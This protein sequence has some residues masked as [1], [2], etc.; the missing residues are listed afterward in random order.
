M[1]RERLAA[2]IEAQRPHL[3]LWA[4]VLLA[5]GIALYFTLPVEPEGWMLAALA[6]AGGVG[7]ATL[8]RL[9]TLGRLVLLALLLPSL[10]LEVAALRAR[11]VAAP[12]LAREMTANVEGRVVGLDRSA[13][14][15]PRVLLDRVV[16]HG[17]EPERTPA[18]VRISLDPATPPDLL[19]PGLRLLGQ[20]RLSP[21]GAPAEPGGF[22]YRR[23]AW[24]ERIG[25]VGYARTPMVE[26]WGPDPGRFR[27]LPFRIRMAASA[28]I[29]RVVPGQD[30]A[31]T[32][33]ILTG[34]RSG[35]DRSVEAALRGSSLYHIVSISGL[36]MTLLAAA[37]FAMI[38]YGLALVPGLALFWPLK[39]VAAVVALAAGAAYL[40]ISGSEVP[41]QRSYVM[42]AT[43]LIA[44]L[45]DRPA[46]T[47][48][49]VALAGLIVLVLTPES[50]V[51][52]GFQMS[53]AA[54]VAL[55][56]AFEGLRGRAW[57]QVTQTAPSWRFARPI[58]AIAM[59]SL[60]AGAAT[61]PISAFH[62]NTVAQYGVLANLLA[63]PA[64]GMV[65]MPASVVAVVASPFGLDWLPFQVA[66]LGMG[67][68]IAV[69]RFVAGL[70]GAVTGVPA[71]PPAS[72]ALILVGAT[73]GVLLV[74]RARW[75]AVAPVALGL[76]L[77]AGHERPQLLIAEN[78]R[79]FGILAPEGRV[80]SSEKGNAYAAESWLRND[81]DRAS[82]PEAWARGRLERRKHR[83][84]AEAPGIGRIV[85]VGTKDPRG[86]GAL[87]AGA[88]VLIAPNWPE[89]PGGRCLF[90][91][92]ER[93]ERAGALAIRPAADGLTLTGAR[94]LNRSRPW[95]RGPAEP[96]EPAGPAP[97]PPAEIASRA[98]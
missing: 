31:F 92:R 54:T 44:V 94:S 58:V 4:P 41:A 14:D 86:A 66:G 75:A 95:T 70:G 29:Q 91:G 93:L 35:I 53:F 98:D 6:G 17:M 76:A 77:W 80:L 7:A 52:P 15:R 45:L 5:L 18:R 72:L 97:Q 60:V 26:T 71:G 13:S 3:A 84:E 33:A 88:A 89:P 67:Y 2:L 9:A 59:T 11:M 62:F 16:I 47:L 48:R 85:Y 23:L 27:Q 1:G 25:A 38:R 42:T 90:V 21:P 55:V 36:H 12:V 37:V 57:W 8:F 82:Q 64:M 28:H 40:V 49:A 78:G 65:V 32:A 74:G 61:A 81:G 30:G 68:I 56:A 83:I 20:A 22:D 69:A 24:F 19:Q 63:I 87:C 10:G 34:D 73:T 79:L 96:K 43:V 46:L 39:K 51:Q 50:L